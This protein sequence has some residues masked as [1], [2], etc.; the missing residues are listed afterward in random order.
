MLQFS[1]KQSAHDSSL[2]FYKTSLGIVLL[3][4]YVDDIVITG[5]NSTLITRLQQHLQASFHMKDL[6]P[7]TYFLGFEVHTKSSGIFLNQHKYTQDL[8]ALASLQDTSSVEVNTKYRQEEGD[9]LS[10]PTMYH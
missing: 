4:V 8:I 10:D 6:G 1:F 7:L 5:T 2:F 9:L 3:L